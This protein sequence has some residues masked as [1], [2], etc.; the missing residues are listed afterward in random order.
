MGKPGM[1][2]SRGWVQT[3]ATLA[4]LALTNFVTAQEFPKTSKFEDIDPRIHTCEVGAHGADIDG[5]I[6]WVHGGYAVYHIDGN[7]TALPSTF[8]I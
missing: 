4:C 8:P 3:C 2:R 6:L 7:Y 1:T 5:D